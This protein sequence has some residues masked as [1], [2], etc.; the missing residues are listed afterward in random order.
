MKLTIMVISNF[1]ITMVKLLHFHND[2]GCTRGGK[3][4]AWCERGR[5]KSRQGAMREGRKN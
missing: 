2:K 4:E 3:I 5:K 1:Y